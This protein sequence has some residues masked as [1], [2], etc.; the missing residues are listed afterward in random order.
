[1]KTSGAFEEKRTS[2][3]RLLGLR[4]I[5]VAC[6]SALAV[7]F[8]IIQVPMS[9][10]FA[11]RAYNNHLR[12]LPLRAPR[13]VLFDRHGVVL[14]E[15]RSSFT[16]AIV[17][18]RLRDL[19]ATIERLAR[20]TGVELE[21]IREAVTRRQSEAK[22]RP[23]PVIEHATLAQVAAVAARQL[24]LPGVLIQQV[25]TRKYPEGVAAHAF[26]YVG[27]IRP[28][29]LITPEFEALEPGAIVGQ[30]GL[31][32]V[33]NE[34]L[35]GTDGN[36]R[37][38]VNSVGREIDEL[39]KVP[40][41]DGRRFQLTIDADVQ[42]ALEDGFRAAGF[43][44][45]AAVLDPRNGEML[46]MTS[47]PAFDP[48]AFAAGLQSSTWSRLMNDPLKPMTNRLIQGTY[49][50][51]SI[52]KIVMAVAGLE[53][54][55]ITT[56]TKYFCPGH[57]TFYGRSFKCHK[58]GG[59]GWVSVREALEKSC[60]V[61]FYNVGDRLKI[62]TIHQF[63]AKLGLTGKTGVDLPS[64]VESLVPSTEWKQRTQK[65]PWYPGE[66][67][68][69]AIG[70]GAVSVTPIA[71][72]TMIATVANGGTLVTPHL[73]K[74]V[75]AGDGKG[76]QPIP[77]PAPR[78]ELH[79][80]PAHLQAVRDG[81]WMVVNQAGTGGR[82]RIEGRDVA[83]KTGTSQVVGLQNKSM[84]T[85]RGMD[86]RDNGW[87]VFFAPRDNPQIAGVIFAEHGEHGSSAAPIAKH[88]IQT[89]FAKQEGTPLPVLPTPGA[90]APAA[91]APGAPDAA[92]APTPA[93]PGVPAGPATQTVVARP[94]A[95]VPAASGPSPRPVATV[96]SGRP[97]G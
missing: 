92:P 66:T 73:A 78:S 15:N 12:A 49:S 61:F 10:T 77:T 93:A 40:P 91:P 87:F 21:A 17:R 55:V 85:S 57:G 94:P 2:E 86:T 53:E 30:A 41:V 16:I 28:E 36:R 20:I 59:H 67:I 7:A 9:D 26:G 58:A 37:V 38:I 11:E 62:D 27:E 95:P 35:M 50:P 14:V 80:T 90:P 56:E 63:A 68:S 97:G 60:N 45:A 44:G 33:Y 3:G 71:L 5:F 46:A 70:Q 39:D 96:R 69:V 48:N 72:A 82:A 25:P 13:G 79:I 75:D 74:A 24:E 52:F 76:W 89:F 19:D 64:E 47:L 88:V 29:Q 54:G 22:F 51:G 43:A 31:E 83:G 34:Y 18:D 84:A 65:Q 32:K 8:W 4:V 42:R 1:M 81:L 6:F 23:L